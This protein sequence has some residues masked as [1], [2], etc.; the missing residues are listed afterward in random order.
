[1]PILFVQQFPVIFIMKAAIQL[2]MEHVIRRANVV[3]VEI[4]L[5]VKVLDAFYRHLVITAVALYLA[6]VKAV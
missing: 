1:M 4:K 6:V 3:Q 2:G 5:D